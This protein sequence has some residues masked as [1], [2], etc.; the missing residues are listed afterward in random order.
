MAKTPSAGGKNTF[1]D[2]TRET[3]VTVARL[4]AE[5][6]IHAHAMVVVDKNGSLAFHTKHNQDL[7]KLM[8]GTSHLNSYMTETYVEELQRARNTAAKVPVKSRV[9][10]T[11]KNTKR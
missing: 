5:A 7:L 2:E 10:K 3:L 9:R 1:A 8:V 6:N 4:L 11:T